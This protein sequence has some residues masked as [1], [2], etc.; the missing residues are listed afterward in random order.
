MPTESFSMIKVVICDHMGKR[1]LRYLSMKRAK[2]CVNCF[3]THD[4]YRMNYDKLLYP[5]EY[6]PFYEVWHNNRK[7]GTFCAD[8]KDG[9]LKEWKD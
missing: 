9:F 5:I 7:I 8:E 1:N 2:H 4:I 3:L 6:F